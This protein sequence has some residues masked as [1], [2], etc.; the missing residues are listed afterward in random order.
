MVATRLRHFS[1]GR[2]SGVEIDTELFT[3]SPPS[4]TG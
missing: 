4:A 1:S 3:R 2:G